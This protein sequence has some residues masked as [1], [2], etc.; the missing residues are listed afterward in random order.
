MDEEEE[1]RIKH[2]EYVREAAKLLNQEGEL[3]AKSQGVGAEEQDIE[4][5]VNKME[6]IVQRNLQIYTDLQNRIGRF[7]RL[8][9]EEE[10]AHQN[11]RET[12]YY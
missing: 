6:S 4:D 2:V 8:L 12:F 5:Y 11:V 10:E 1:L 9:K 3:I 7:K